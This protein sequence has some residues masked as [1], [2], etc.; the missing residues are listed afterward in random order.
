MWESVSRSPALWAQGLG[1]LWDSLQPGTVSVIH[2]STHLHYALW[3]NYS[4]Y[5]DQDM[6]NISIMKQMLAV[7]SVYTRVAQFT[8]NH[9]W[10]TAVTWGCSD[11]TWST[12]NVK[13][14]IE[15]TEKQCV[16]TNTGQSRYPAHDPNVCVTCVLQLFG[17]VCF[18]CNRVIEGDG[19]TAWYKHFNTVQHLC[20]LYND[21]RIYTGDSHVR[22]T[23]LF[24][25]SVVSALNKAWCVKCFSCSTC[26]SKLTLKCV[27]SLTLKHI[28]IDFSSSGRLGLDVTSVDI[29]HGSFKSVSVQTQSLKS[30]LALCVFL[31]L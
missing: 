13:G 1:V 29:S 11:F 23:L 15:M 24:C 27:R 2:R 4:V 9:C 25:L 5:Q 30:K 31:L 8:L 12:E 10:D 19:E 7:C 22:S 20:Y 16:P 6:I 3:M 18:H 26:N 28:H 21:L 17:D 14:V